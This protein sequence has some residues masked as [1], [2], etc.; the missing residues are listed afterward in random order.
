MKKRKQYAS[1][2]SKKKKTRVKKKKNWTKEKEDCVF[3]VKINNFDLNMQMDNGKLGN[4]YTKKFL[5]KYLKAD[6]TKEQV[7]S[8]PIWWVGHKKNLRQFD[9]S[10]IK[11]NLLVERYLGETRRMEAIRLAL[12]LWEVMLVMS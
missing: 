9:G 12:V 6:F 2:F 7:T 3:K 5:K 8:P 1:L 4:A 10:V 11:K